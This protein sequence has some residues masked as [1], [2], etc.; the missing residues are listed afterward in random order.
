MRD[1]FDLDKKDYDENWPVFRRPSARAIICR[2]GKVLMI[3]S[4][5]YD[6]YKFPGGGIES[7]EDP[8]Q[9]LCREVTE[10]T[11]RVV[12]PESIEEYGR[13]LRRQK[14]DF[15]DQIFEQEN[16]YFFCEI[17]EE[18][19]ETKL[20]DYEA[21]E[22]FHAVWIEPMSAS[23]HNRYWHN[24]QGGDAVIVE[25]EA[26]VLD[27]ADLELRKRARL[28]EERAFVKGL[29]SLD[30]ADM[31]SFVESKLSEKSEE[32]I[33]AKSEINYSRF[34]H[35]KRVLGWAK[36]L[37]DATAES[38]RSG[39]RYEDLIIATIFHDVGRTVSMAT[40]EP[41]AKAGIP[42]TRAYLQEHGF[43]AARTEYICGLVGAH[44]DKDR[45]KEPG[46]DPTLLMLMEADLLDDMGALGIVMDCMITKG[47]NPLAQFEDCLDHIFRYTY[48]LQQENPMVSEVGRRLWDEKTE[49][50]NRFAEALKQDVCLGFTADNQ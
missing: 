35:T 8:K 6:Y 34:N 16:L 43:D 38:E 21:E 11:G 26:K 3:H 22:G 32:Q 36:R 40:K 46:M 29:G 5:L 7:G 15:G 4:K 1:L 31:L 30:Y 45:M 39:I 47:R 23:R 9:A 18:T 28:A 13:V 33:S 25:R 44:S 2:E 49:L 17:S 42:I 48:P 50:V 14:D 20:D 12:N 19:S 41:H 10:E 24:G 37:Y 27:M